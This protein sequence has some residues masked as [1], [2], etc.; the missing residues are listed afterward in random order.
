M[1]LVVSALLAI[2]A[3]GL[4]AVASTWRAEDQE[5]LRT[6]A[7]KNCQSIEALKT[8]FRKQALENYAQLERNA[9]LL[10]IEVTDEVRAAALENRN[11][12]LRR[13]KP[14]SCDI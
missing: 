7:M 11:R 3:L 9:R 8:Q 14:L 13:F 6:V 1:L 10:D 5:Q 2:A 12:T 4:V